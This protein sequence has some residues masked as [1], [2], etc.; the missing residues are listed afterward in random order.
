M[1]NMQEV[2]RVEIKGWRYIVGLVL[3]VAEDV[4]RFVGVRHAV[5]AREDI[6]LGFVGWAWRGSVVSVGVSV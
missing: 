1:G 6:G 3:W 5:Q 4:W 2:E